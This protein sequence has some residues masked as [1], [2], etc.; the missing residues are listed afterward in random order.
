MIK[1][2]RKYYNLVECYHNK[3]ALFIFGDNTIQIGKAGQAVIRGLSNSFGIPTKW[4]PSTEDNA[5]FDDKDYDKI[6]KV[7]ND[8]FNELL[9]Y[10]KQYNDII[11]P[12]M[13]LGTGLSELPTRA[14]KVFKLLNDLLLKHF[15]LIQD[16][17]GFLIEN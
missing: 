7:L 5:Y 1:V 4:F 12:K 10:S 11:F 6:E 3:R 16:E 2:Q 9:E 17:T 14:P 13:G 15:N 8:K